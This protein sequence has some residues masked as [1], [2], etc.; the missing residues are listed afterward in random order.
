MDQEPI[1]L[2]VYELIAEQYAARVDTKPHNAFYDRPA[3][4]SLTCLTTG[5]PSVR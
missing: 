3:T 4:P 1:A 2:R 5:A